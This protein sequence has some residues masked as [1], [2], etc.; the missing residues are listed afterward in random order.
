MANAKDPYQLL[1]ISKSASEKEIKQA[2]RKLA[3]QSHPDLNPG[4]KAQEQKFKELTAAYDLLSDSDKKARFDRGELD[5]DG[6]PTM[7]GFYRSGGQPGADADMGGFGSFFRNAGRGQSSGFGADDF[8]SEIFGRGRGK[9]K[10]EQAP[11][12]KGADVTYRMAVPFIAAIEGTKSKLKLIDGTQV[13]ISIPKGAD[14]G[15]KIRL[16]GKGK[17]GQNGGPSGDAL[18]ELHIKSH[19]FFKREKLMITLDLP[20]T[21]SEALN[22]GKVRVPTLTGSVMLSIP[23]GSN[24][25]QVLRL[26]GKGVVLDGEKGDLLVKLQ[27]KLPEAMPATLKEAIAAFEKEHPYDLRQALYEHKDF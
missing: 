6:N 3:K 11:S 9:A 23:A 18:V 21:L 17:P 5:A 8:L 27:I 22:G 2:Y 10:K 1:G 13:E 19:P 26:P 20:I 15:Q 7:G 16:A 4:N 12:V 25:G 24:S 14:D